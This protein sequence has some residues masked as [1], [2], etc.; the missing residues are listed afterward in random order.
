MGLGVIRALGVVGVPVI[1]VYYDKSDMGYVSKYVTESIHAPHPEQFDEQFVDLLI[2]NA[3]RFDRGL[4]IPTDD[5]TLVT[6]SRYKSQLERCYTVACTEWEVTEKFIDKKHTYALADA[7]GVPAP[8]TVVPQS[9]KDVESY[10]QAAQYPC[11]VK[12]SQSHRYFDL[13]GV[14]MVRAD[15]FSEL[16]AAYK[17][18]ADSGFDVMVQELIPGDDT[19][20]ANYNS[21]F[22]DG[23]PLAEFTAQQV[24]NAPPEFGSPRVVVSKHIP[25]VIEPGRKILQAMG[26]YGYSCTEFKKDARDGVYKLMEVNGRHNRSGLLAVRCGMNFPWIQYRHLVQGELPSVRDYRKDVFWIDL[27][28]DVSHSIMYRGKE[29]GKEVSYIQPYLEQ[30]VFSTFDLKDPRP[31]IR[32]CK[33]LAKRVVNAL[34]SKKKKQDLQRPGTGGEFNAI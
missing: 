27:T 32:R 19:R 25:E 23:A 24:R 12:P 15:S 16:L 4:L 9:V 14:K 11:L 3:A 26:F 34:F 1:A 10:H 6:V 28:R 33:D 20:G 21:Y 29:K 30:H 31:F 7:I 13:F 5:A 8:R 18:A 17:Q 22:W 2:E